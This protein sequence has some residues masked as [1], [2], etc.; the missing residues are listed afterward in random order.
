MNNDRP[1]EKS[2]SIVHPVLLSPLLFAVKRGE[3]FMNDAFAGQAGLIWC[4]WN[5]LPVPPGHF[6]FHCC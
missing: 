6:R 3:S 1:F 2:F 5:N 4:N